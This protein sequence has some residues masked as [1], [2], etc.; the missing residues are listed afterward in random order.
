MAL[1]GRPRHDLRRLTRFHFYPSLAM[2][3]QKISNTDS[4]FARILRKNETT[5]ALLA[6]TLL[7]FLIHGEALN[8]SWRWDD[9]G[10]LKFAIDHTPFDYFFHSKTAIA[11][12]FA[13]VAPWNILFYDLNL[14]LFGM[15]ARWHYVHLQII[16]A[17]GITF[18]YKTLRQWIAPIP[19]SISVF[20]ILLGKPTFHIA[21][22]LMHGHYATGFAFSM[23]CI[24][25]WTNYLRK[26]EGRHLL[27]SVFLYLLATTCKEIYVPLPLILPLIP[28]GNA[29]QRLIFTAPFFGVTALYMA[30]RFSI[31][32]VFIGGYSQGKFETQNAI[33][34]LSKIPILLMD[35]EI[36]GTLTIATI[37]FLT[38]LSFLKNKLNH[39]LIAGI[40]FITI[41]PLVPLTTYPGINTPD[42]Y[43]LIP[44]V[45]LCA[46]IAITL[47][48]SKFYITAIACLIL[49]PSLLI[50]HENGKK[51]VYQDIVFWDTIYYFSLIADKSKQAIFV[52]PDD[53]FR[54]IVLTG[55]RETLE[56]LQ[57]QQSPHKL[58]TVNAAGGGLQEARDLGLQLFETDGNNI[59]SMSEERIAQAISRK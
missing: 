7:T 31:L 37:L 44:W 22:G 39:P 12:S 36:H 32:G 13:H 5:I 38:T 47:N 51:E 11:Y 2:D 48:N 8:G 24:F 1:L 54:K 50:I 17:L 3:I 46:L 34:H 40:A 52:G 59:V 41:A 4:A 19:A 14:S 45:A 18:F 9:G 42:R 20:A 43:L 21:A 53:G 28:A 27:F 33:T 10:H 58:I 26:N 25:Y 29:R 55:A 49:T 35:R 15:E 56:K 16:L 6:I 30:W 23:L 57:N